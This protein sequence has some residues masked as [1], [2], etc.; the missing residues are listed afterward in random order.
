MLEI[1]WG[2][3]M[4]ILNLCRPYLIALAVVL[5][6]VLAV[7][8]AGKKAE[9]SKRKLIRSEAGIAF[10]LAVVIVVN[11]IC[12]GP[13]ATM[14]S[15]AT[16]NGTITDGT[17][18]EAEAACESIA[19][20]GIVLLKNED[21]VLPLNGVENLNVFGW[22]STNPC[23]G[24]TGSG[25][26]SDAY[27]KVTLLQGLENAGFNLNTGLEEF[28]TE[29]RAEHPTIS[30]FVQDW[31]L[32]EPPAD[33]YPEALLTEAKE[34][35][36]TALIVLS[37]TG[38]E[39]ADLPTDITN[40]EETWPADSETFSASY[41]DNS[42]DYEDFPEGTHYLELSQ[43]ERDMVELVC[44]NFDNVVVIYNGSN[45][46]EMGFV[47]EYEQIKGAVWCAGP[48]Q[49]GFNALGNVLNG[50]VNPSG[51][52]SDI[53]A[54][55]YTQA[56]YFNNI[57]DFTYDNMTEYAADSWGD[58]TSPTFVNYV[59]GIYVGYKFYETAAD[60]G[61][62]DYDASVVYPFGYGLSYTIF[63]QEMSDITESDGNI[64][65]DVTVT[66]TGNSAGKDVIE[67]YY[68]PPYTNGGIEKATANLVEFE[69]TELLEA[70]E[71]QTF[72]ITF[73]AE[74]MASFDSDDA[75]AYVLESGD[76]NISINR[77]SH[78]EIASQI[79]HVDETIVF[80]ED[81][82][83]FT[84]ETAATTQLADSEGD[85]TYL[86]R[87]DNFANYA[88]ATAAPTTYTLGDEY[89][90]A[91]LNN[92]VY[93]PEDYN[94]ADDEMPTTGADNG[95]SL[96]ELRGADYDD[97]RWEPLLD[98]LTVSEMNDLIALGGY[99]T[100]EV[101][102]VDKVSTIDCD[103]P[104]SI[105]NNF[106]G[107]GSIGFPS[108]TMIACTWNKDKALEFGEGI[109][110]MADEMGVSGWYA[111]AMNIHRSPFAGRNFEYYSED[112]VLSGIMVANAV[113][114]A[115]EH[116]VYAYIK[117]FAL[118]D[119]E[120]NRQS[121]L[122][123]WSDEQAT[124]EIYLKPFEIA[125]KAGGAQAVMSSYNYIG[126]T[127]AGAKSELLNNILR[128]E[129]GFEGMVLTD[130]FGGFGYMDADQAIRNGGDNCLVAYDNGTNYV[131]DT[132]SA[133]SV[134]AMRRAAKNILYTVVNSRAYESE[135]INNGLMGWQ[136]AAIVIDVVLAAALIA[137]EVLTVQK[138]K[139]RN[140]ARV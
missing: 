38:A 88:E 17:L 68:N 9:T 52:T 132:T 81:N 82:A 131:E 126:V 122:C 104:A 20:E 140:K 53:F 93:N 13:M 114:G 46:M 24:G 1:N 83:R 103:G 85:V 43:S 41:E 12:F 99:S 6:I 121:M 61:L 100:A 72:T 69:K 116:G 117:H 32:P 134:Q 74:D 36:D 105:N 8:A 33:T 59:E 51:R 50:T 3:V 94:N 35:S 112:G 57:G 106:T 111:P 48:G 91:F 136:I 34:F 76:Y 108:A 56:P 102:S 125:V 16:G 23:Y 110:Q 25:A 44:E 67:V 138:Y 92:A 123:T 115:G 62:I 19:E 127:W 135:N 26:I 119:Q 64:T 63:T 95:M 37:R 30:P 109:G 15:L 79:Y 2:D 96:E 118:N 47:N 73:A 87:A 18:A 66:N 137:L 22:A 5:V 49:N 101:S 78:T 29:Y 98:Q 27:E 55:D 4:N 28:Y 7:V 97:D 133:T 45:V 58:P 11:L 107:V 129:W 120:T 65:F 70:G 75:G 14:I 31:T 40:V 54:A 60:E 42:E 71:S 139:K 90:E 89:K 39:H 128:D 80:D 10:L 124:R 86:S 113:K 77:D 130:Y 21:N 84:D